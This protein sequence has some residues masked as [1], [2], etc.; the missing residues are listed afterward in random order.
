MIDERK[1]S[2]LQKML[3]QKFKLANELGGQ[4]EGYAKKEE[5]DIEAIRFLREEVEKERRKS[6]ADQGVIRKLEQVIADKVRL[7]EESNRRNT[8][9][10]NEIQAIQD[11]LEKERNKSLVDEATIKKLE[12]LLSRKGE[13]LERKNE[14]F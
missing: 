7:V 11:E 12:D 6:Q 10:E 1:L 14:E 13:E 5:D 9:L 3:D 2:D 8:A 4:M